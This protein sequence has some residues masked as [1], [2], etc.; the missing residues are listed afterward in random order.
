MS[1]LRKL[2]KIV[3]PHDERRAS[4]ELSPTGAASPRRSL[5]HV[6]GREN[7]D[8]ISSSEGESDLSDFDSDGMSKNAQKRMKTKERKK[9]HRSR[10]S[11]EQHDDSSE[12][13]RVRLEEAA[14]TETEEEKSKYGELPIMQ[15]TARNVT[16][17]IDIDT[18]SEDMIGQEV[19][20]RARLHHVRAMGAKLVFLMFRQ[21][22]STVQGVLLEE[23]GVVSALMIHWAE[24]LRTGNIMLVTG[25]IQKPDIPIKSASIH[26]VEVRVTQLKL[27]AK[28]AEPG[29]IPYH[30]LYC[31]LL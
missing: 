18:I 9:E 12:H 1:A 4:G 15:S 10:L 13:S 31:E 7:K 3:H 17:R 21:Q 16:N 27:I 19:T 14:K 30:L 20:F 2:S 24:H 11:L 6:F 26:T 5:A 8:Y 22:I 29:I 28:R 23:P 25:K